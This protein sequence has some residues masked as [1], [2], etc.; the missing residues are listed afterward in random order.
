MY[1]KAS[2]FSQQHEFHKSNERGNWNDVPT[3]PP[4]VWARNTSGFTLAGEPCTSHHLHMIFSTGVTG[5]Q[6]VEEG[7]QPPQSTRSS[8]RKEAIKRK[9]SVSVSLSVSDTHMHTHTHAHTHAHTCT[10][11]C[12][13][14]HAR[15]HTHQ[16]GARCSQLFLWT[17]DI[18]LVGL[19]ELTEGKCTP[20]E[21]GVVI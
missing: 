3:K 13:R 20:E 12:T 21:K 1:T 10:Y 4:S 6:G 9:D 18:L 5:S 14:T 7:S 2:P 8:R 15:T 19:Q 17:P 16:F 11:A